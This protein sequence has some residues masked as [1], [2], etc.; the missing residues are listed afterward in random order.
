MCLVDVQYEEVVKLESDH[1]D[2]S[3]FL[4][5]VYRFMAGQNRAHSGSASFTD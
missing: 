2:V 1:Y 5:F 3:F 4:M